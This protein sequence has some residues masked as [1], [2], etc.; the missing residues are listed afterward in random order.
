MHLDTWECHHWRLPGG[1][2]KRWSGGEVSAVLVHHGEHHNGS[3][4]APTLRQPFCCLA[5][6]PGKQQSFHSR[7][8]SALIATPDQSP[9]L[10]GPFQ[11]GQ[12]SGITGILVPQHLEGH[13]LPLTMFPT[14]NSDTIFCWGLWP[15][16]YCVC[17]C[18]MEKAMGWGADWAVL[19]SCCKPAFHF[20]KSCAH[21]YHYI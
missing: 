2:W 9:T 4:P 17:L 18:L 13:K 15:Y 11:H 10:T 20:L 16:F 6:P 8:P 19:K 14:C 21:Y 12:W 1:G 5:P 7:R 3:A